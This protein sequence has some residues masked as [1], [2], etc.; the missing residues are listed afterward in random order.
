M[1]ALF[2]ALGAALAV[3]T[4]FGNYAEAQITLGPIAVGDSYVDTTIAPAGTCANGGATLTCTYGGYQS[5]HKNVLGTVVGSYCAC[6]PG[7]TGP[8]GPAGSTGATG[9]AGSVGPKGDTGSSGAVGATGPVGPSGATGGVGPKGDRGDVG[10]AGGI[11]PQGVPGTGVIVR[12]VNGAEVTDYIVRNDRPYWYVNGNFWPMTMD[13][14]LDMSAL[15]AVP[16]QLHFH[17]NTCTGQAY[18]PASVKNDVRW[19]GSGNLVT[20][21]TPSTTATQVPGPFCWRVIISGGAQCQQVGCSEAYERAVTLHTG[22]PLG[23]PTV[24]VPMYLDRR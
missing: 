12:D 16:D 18:V 17:D 11:G 1:K 24:A 6:F 20:L 19:G 2:L 5:Q 4:A 10:P 7:N 23:K 8:Q 15:N 3:T 13:N 14:S 21:Y 9:P 22:F